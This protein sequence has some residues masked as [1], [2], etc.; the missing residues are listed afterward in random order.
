RTGKLWCS[1]N[2]GIFRFD[3]R[4]REIYSF[5]KSDG[6]QGNEFNRAHKFRFFDGRLAFGGTE[7]YTIFN[8]A[9]FEGD[10]P[11]TPV[12]IQ[13]TSLQINNQLKHPS[14]PGSIVQEPLSL[15]SEINLP[16][17]KSHL[18][19]E[20]AALLFNQP[21][22]TKYRFQMVGIDKQWVENGTSNV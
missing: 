13:L 6:L 11:E 16:S 10:F 14:R 1:T 7:G 4:T 8:P 19:F 12:P 17:D 21:V 9:D 22:K 2:K 18:R 3:P 5:E 15:I 20:F